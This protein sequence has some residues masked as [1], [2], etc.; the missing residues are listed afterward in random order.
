M[1][2]KPHR[3]WDFAR[4]TT[5]RAERS[6]G[7]SIVVVVP[8]VTFVRRNKI[9]PT[10]IIHC[11]RVVTLW[12]NEL[13]LGTKKIRSA[14]RAGSRVV[15]VASCSVACCGCLTGAVSTIG[16]S[17][18]LCFFWHLTFVNRMRVWGGSSIPLSSSRGE[19]GSD[20]EW[21]ET[22]I[23][24]MRLS[25]WGKANKVRQGAVVFYS[26]WFKACRDH[27]PLVL[28]VISTPIIEYDT[29]GKRSVA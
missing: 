24:E 16:K 2:P 13:L 15:D 26:I 28:S 23:L 22:S 27:C 29:W 17:I 20:P 19:I 25:S 3:D 1:R 10:S 5:E 7:H 8:L 21:E 9:I 12:P 18:A 11:K 14:K 4:T 6:E